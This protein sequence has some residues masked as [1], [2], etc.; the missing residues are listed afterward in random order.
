[1]K[2]ASASCKDSCQFKEWEDTGVK[3]LRNEVTISYINSEISKFRTEYL[4]ILHLLH[5]V[6][7]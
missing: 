6:V 4:L 5:I 2:D 3:R 7:T 1:M